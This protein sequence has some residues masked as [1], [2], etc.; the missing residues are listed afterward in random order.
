MQELIE[1]VTHV[2]QQLAK[3]TYPNE[4]A[5]RSQI[6][7]PIFER[8]GWPVYDAS[9]FCHEYSLQTRTSTRRVDIA[10]CVSNGGSP[11]CIIELK[12]PGRVEGDEQLFE[13]AFHAGAPLALLTNGTQW[14]LYHILVGGSYAE[15]LVRT[16]DLKRHDAMEVATALDRY[17]SYA[18][19][20]SGIAPEYAKQDLAERIN[21]NK[22]KEQ[23]PK[24]WA[25]L[26]ANQD[27]RLI[28]LLVDETASF[29]DYAPNKAD[30][31]AFL[32]SLNPPGQPIPDPPKPNN[33][34]DDRRR[35][36]SGKGPIRYHLLGAQFEAL[37]AKQALIDIV[38]KL[39]ERDSTML[40]RL[41]PK[42]VRRTTKGLAR[43]RDE[44]AQSMSG[45]RAAAELPGGWWLDTN[46]S[47]TK[48]QQ[49]LE[50]FCKAAGIPFNN[51]E[52][53]KIDLP[54]A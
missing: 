8:L 13:Y 39:A 12:W 6:V 36:K 41:A 37:T 14:H 18:N 11:R 30:V 38:S 27:N 2:R 4:T 35:R 7:Q 33:K 5:V 25:Q 48:K 49:L 44:I 9:R 19:T 16:L 43:A 45:R 23:I 50:T 47:N 1:F 31:L 34:T 42:L 15:R 17:L 32:R 54:N 10:L 46:L 26:T 24:A 22:A 28:N 51:A 21:R 20:E 40:P 3:N 53:L 29:S 52:G